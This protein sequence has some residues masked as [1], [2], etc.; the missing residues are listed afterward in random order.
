MLLTENEAKEKRCCGPV[1]CGRK[2]SAALTSASDDRF[3][4]G[5]ACMGWRWAG[6]SSLSQSNTADELVP[7][8]G[9]GP[10]RLQ[11]KEP[12]GKGWRPVYPP[13]KKQWF[14]W[15][16]WE[17]PDYSNAI[18]CCGYAPDENFERIARRLRRVETELENQDKT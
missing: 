2:P 7:S 5:S 16:N 10:M 1:G 18:G 8:D 13:D 4:I 14:G 3:C 6:W 15:T 11:P 17:R 9:K 12:N